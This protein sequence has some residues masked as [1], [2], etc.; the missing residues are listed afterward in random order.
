M[1]KAGQ[2]VWPLAAVKR[3]TVRQT[4]FTRLSTRERKP[5]KNWYEEQQ[6]E[7]RAPCGR[8]EDAADQNVTARSTCPTASFRSCGK[9]CTALTPPSRQLYKGKI[10]PRIFERK[11]N[12]NRGRSPCGRPEEAAD[13]DAAAPPSA[14]SS[15]VSAS[16]SP[17]RPSSARWLSARTASERR[18]AS[19]RLRKST[20]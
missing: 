1:R 14:V 9:K 7:R 13:Q 19:L 2:L 20:P 8:P 12:S 10:E 4:L 17:F 6:Q 11:G 5:C 16:N 18:S 15:R 3:C